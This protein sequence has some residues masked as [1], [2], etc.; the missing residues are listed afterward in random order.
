M[1]TMTP[2]EFQAALDA[3]RAEGF[4]EGQDALRQEALARILKRREEKPTSQTRFNG[5]LK[6]LEV[7][8]DVD[9]SSSTLAY[10]AI[11][12]LMVA[13]KQDVLVPISTLR[14][15][16]QKLCDER[17]AQHP[18]VMNMIQ[19]EQATPSSVTYHWFT[20]TALLY[21]MEGV[22]LDEGCEDDRARLEFVRARELSMAYD[23]ILR[24]G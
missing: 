2:E 5:L 14:R 3:A 15:L 9:V 24:E 19:P 22:E 13:Q 20:K 4:R 18:E 10:I 6:E 21:L 8:A 17:W 16:Y 1:L 7:Y 12:L 11:P 23:K